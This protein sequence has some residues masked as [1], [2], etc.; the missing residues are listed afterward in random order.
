MSGVNN[1]AVYGTEY[2]YTIKEGAYTISSGVASYEPSLGGDENPLRQPISY[3]QKIK[4][5]LSNMFYLEQPFG[6]SFFP[7]PSV[8]YRKVTIKNIN[9]TGIADPQNKTGWI[10]NEF[11]TAKEFPTLVSETAMQKNEVKPKSKMSLFGGLQYHELVLSQGYVIYLNDMHGKARKEEVYDKQGALISST[12]YVYNATDLNPGEWQLNNSVK[13]INDNG[14]VETKTLGRDIEMYTDMRESEFANLGT[15]YNLGG[16]AFPIP[17]FPGVGGL[18][19]WPKKNNDEIRLFRSACIAKVIQSFGIVQKVIKIQNG[20]LVTAENVAFDPNTGDVLVTKTHNEFKQDIFSV[21]IPAYWKYKQMGGAYKTLGTFINNFK[22][23]VNGIIEGTALNSFVQPGDELIDDR[24]KIYWVIE[25]KTTVN[26]IESPA[27]TKRLIN[28]DGSIATAFAAA[29]RWAKIIRSGNRNLISNTIATFVS[30]VDPIEDNKLKFAENIELKNW[31]IIDAKAT[32]FNEDWTGDWTIPC[33]DCPEGY[34]LSYD[35]YCEKTIIE[36]TSQC[37]TLCPGSNHTDNSID[38]AF[39]KETLTSPWVNK[40][41]S[42]WGGADCSGGGE[43]QMAAASFIVPSNET[44]SVSMAAALPNPCN[45]SSIRDANAC[46]PLNRSGVWFCS[47]NQN[48]ERLPLNQ[49]IGVETYK[50]V[51]I[52]KTYYLGYGANDRIRI[53]IN[54]RPVV[55]NTSKLDENF[56]HWSVIPITLN[57]GKNRIRIEGYNDLGSAAMGV[58]IYDNTYAQLINGTSAN[59]IFTSND[60]L[61]QNRVYTYAYNPDNTITARYTCSDGSMP[62]VLNDVT[63]DRFK[64]NQFNPYVKGFKGN[65]RPFSSHVFQVNRSYGNE[66]IAKQNGINI[67]KDGHYKEF[68]PFWVY[69]NGTWDKNTTLHP[70]KWVT[71]NTMTLYDRYGQELETGMPSIYT[72]LQ[73]SVF[74]VTWPRP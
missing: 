9:E 68:A 60:L 39:I 14:G 21:N 67:R 65:W 38:G 16:D 15:S 31:K 32:V 8:G 44:S 22:T 47:S 25:S 58:E 1:K 19:H 64:V 30:L 40:K 10:I 74:L 52:T 63:C 37:F 12:E 70:E 43:G 71:A 54:N 23:D 11:Y 73:P 27:S 72:V 5:A 33:Q 7:A 69:N 29:G 42:F 46:S 28:K 36:N 20:S 48:N 50:A 55:L 51:A 45:V 62:D 24:G 53:Y 61:S 59:V 34:T 57:A 35:G 41:S 17:F 18:P 4:G 56:R 6:E 3:Q 49:W 66:A 13:I 2:D 26:G